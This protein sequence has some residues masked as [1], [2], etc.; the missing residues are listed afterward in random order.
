M[1]INIW[2]LHLTVNHFLLKEKAP[3]PIN[4][5]KKPNKQK[6][7]DH[8]PDSLVGEKKQ[9]KTKNPTKQTENSKPHKIYS[10]VVTF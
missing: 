6:R 8:N 10:Y 7:I 4:P 1:W 5:E 3:I 9:I 2:Q